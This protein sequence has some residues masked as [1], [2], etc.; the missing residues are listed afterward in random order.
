VQPG[1]A[2][3]ALLGTDFNK[4][5]GDDDGDMGDGEVTEQDGDGKDVQFSELF[6]A[7]DEVHGQQFALF[8]HYPLVCTLSPF[9]PLLLLLHVAPAGHIRLVT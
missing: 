5:V 8:V 3:D 1:A 4:L 9:K 7:I 6:D 2:G